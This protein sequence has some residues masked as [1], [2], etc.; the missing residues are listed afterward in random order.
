MRPQVQHR[1][2]AVA[3]LQKIVAMSRVL[4]EKLDP[5]GEKYKAWED[6]SAEYLKRMESQLSSGMVAATRNTH[7]KTHT[8]K[9]K[10]I[11][12]EYS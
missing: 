6:M 11:S 7:G 3:E 12:F 9:S 5:M 2:V 8:L 10:E 1:T 4:K